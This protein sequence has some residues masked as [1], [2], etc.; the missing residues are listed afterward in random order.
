MDLCQL[1]EFL[2]NDTSIEQ[3]RRADENTLR[4]FG[5]RTA[6]E[7]KRAIDPCS[8]VTSFFL[9]FVFFDTVCLR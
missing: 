7:H 1:M 6:M 4:I 3:F 9:V 2:R 8:D 5:A